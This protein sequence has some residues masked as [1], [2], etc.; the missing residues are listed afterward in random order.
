MA[1]SKE[2]K[3]QRDRFLA[4]AFASADLFLEVAE[5]EKVVFALG[6]A[7]SLTGIEDRAL[8]GHQWLD[9]F[10]KPDRIALAGMYRKA[11]EGQRCGPIAVTMDEKLGGGQRAIVTGIRMPGTGSFY[12]TIGF[13]T[14]LMQRLADEIKEHASYELL[15]KDK[16][17]YAAKEAL[18]IARS[19]G[20]E[21]DMTLLDIPD[22]EKI[23]KRLGDDW[24]NT[25]SAT[26]A[27]ILGARSVD[28]HSVAEIK[29]GRFSVIHDKTVTT[30]ALRAE[31]EAAAKKADES[32]A[33]IEIQGK[34][35]S[36]D[37][38]SITERDAMKALIYTIN[39][40]ERKGTAMNIDTLN[41][42]FK[43]YVSANAQKIQQFKTMISQLSF[44]FNF[45]PIVTLKG[46]ALS[47]FEM[48]VRFADEG[49]TQE[50]IVFGEDLGMAADLDIAVCERAINYLLYKAS[51]TRTKFSINLSGQSIQN[52]QFFKTLMAKLMMNKGL[53]QRVVFEI[54]ESSRITELAMVSN[55]IETLHKNGYEV[56]LD[57]FGAGGMSFQYLQRLNVDYVKVD[58]QYTQNLLNSNRDAVLLKNLARMC[59]ELDIRVIGERIEEEAQAQ[60]LQELGIEMGQGY[61]FGQPTVKPEYIQPKTATTVSAG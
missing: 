15:D 13:T 33:G 4:F 11:R 39:E 38:Q 52:E 61:Y 35:V 57:D 50:W 27:A 51:N 49:S 47:H 43:A 22:A 46:A 54:T 19:V 60:K 8:L 45:Q 53:G 40:F 37:L 26:I 28:G 7:R 6:A 31:I 41:S 59:K 18:D 20:Q 5:N 29:D 25:F 9:V 3:T 16:F 48:L 17:L 36:S 23:R 55:F 56:C 58:R 2:I 10:A 34:T 1:D 42:G 30:D 14:A 12:L 32:G 44:T 24:W 21:L